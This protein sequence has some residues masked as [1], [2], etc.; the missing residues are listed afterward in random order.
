MNLKAMKEQLNDLVAH[1]KTLL[2]SAIEECRSLD[3]AQTE[4]LR[5]IDVE[6]ENL[7]AEITK[8]EEEQRSN[9][10]KQELKGSNNMKDLELR[11]IEKFIKTGNI[12]EEIRATTTGAMNTAIQPTY[13][14][15]EI[16]RRLEEVAPVFAKAKLYQATAGELKIPREDKA[17]LWEYGFVGEDA[18][19]TEHSF[20][21][22]TVSLKQVRVGASVKITQQ[23][24]NNADKH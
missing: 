1:K 20:K 4:E 3:D 11:S 19:V 22:D 18:D 21:F 9:V 7:K 15:D 13:V 12:D 17:N 16:V 8:T 5:S 14:Q 10:E 2:T 24:L 6:I 23:L